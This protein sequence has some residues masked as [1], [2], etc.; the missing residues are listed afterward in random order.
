MQD[1][2]GIGVE[3]SDEAVEKYSAKPAEMAVFRMNPHYKW[4]PYA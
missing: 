3:I 2:A 1:G 4:P